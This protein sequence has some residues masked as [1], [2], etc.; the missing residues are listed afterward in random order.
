MRLHV[1]VFLI[2]LISLIMVAIFYS[3]FTFMSQ[4]ETPLW[5]LQYTFYAFMTAIFGFV[6]LGILAPLIRERLKEGK[7][8]K[9]EE[10][11]AL[12]SLR[13]EYERCSWSIK[14]NI[15][16]YVEKNEFT[17]FEA[18]LH[19]PNAVGEV[20]ISEELKRKVQEF[21][22]R[23]GLYKVLCE[24]SKYPIKSFI[25]AKVRK[26]FR[27]TLKIPFA[28][29]EFLQADYLMARYFNG[30]KVTDSWFK[31]THPT[32]YKNIIKGLDESERDE[33]DTC[34]RELN[35]KFKSDA[36]LQRF[37]K[38]KEELIKHGK[39]TI[40]A[41]Q[42]EI[43]SLNEQLKKYSNLRKVEGKEPNAYKM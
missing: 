42:R 16:K 35:H 38:E 10:K 28:L 20:E 1:R 39:E 25:E 5:I 32:A 17:D 6:F 7:T 4:L 3:L 18:R 8:K 21:N 15:E 26:K 43:N 37:R 22:E 29:D 27:R 36:I 30:E 13:T 12:E 2:G 9:I 11:R 24:A 23:C 19:K 14:N 40:K 33:L 41:F 31:E 34:F